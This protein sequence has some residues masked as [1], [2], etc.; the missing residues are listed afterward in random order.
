MAMIVIRDRIIALKGE[1]M[2]ERHMTSAAE[3]TGPVGDAWAQE[4]Q[5]TDR[6]FAGLAVH[7]DALVR[8]AVCADVATAVDIGCGAGATSIALATA[9]SGVSVIGIDLSPD[10]IATAR[11]RAAKIPNLTF[12]QGSVDAVVARVAPVD[13]FFSR[14]GVMFFDDPVAVLGKVRAAAAPGAR[15]IFSC[16]RDAAS[17]PWATE[18]SSAIVGTA[19][20]PPAPGYAPSPFAFAEPDRVRHI[21]HDAGWRDAAMTPVNFCYRT[22]AG[23]DPVADAV[24]FFT[25]IG[26]AA[27][28]L[29]A[30]APD[31]RAAMLDRIAAVAARYRSGE[32]VDFP[33]AA[34]LWSART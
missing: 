29:R 14:H 9:H 26:P 3:W 13:L 21:L 15:L 7:L 33:A 24:S 20:A 28:A 34:W 10:L 30:A 23:D 31:A 19:P 4:W 16:F 18:I 32:V 1:R 5:R 2:T 22:G 12:E 6:S 11:R 25:T 17:N 27:P 8:E